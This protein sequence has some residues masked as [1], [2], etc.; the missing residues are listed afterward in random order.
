V[1]ALAEQQPA[2][3][4]VP[5][6]IVGVIAAC[7]V[8]VLAV[9]HVAGAICLAVVLLGSLNVY[10]LAP[11]HD[12]S[13][14]VLSLAL[15]ALVGVMALALRLSE[16][17]PVARDAVL[18][19]MLWLALALAVPIV[20]VDR[21]MLQLRWRQVPWQ[22][23][24]AACGIPAGVAGELILRPQPLAGLG[25]PAR[26]AAV[27]LALAVLVAPSLE[28]LFRWVLNPDLVTLYGR[29]GLLLLNG[30]FAS[31]YLGTRSAGF[32]LLMGVA[33]LGLSV[34]VSRTRVVWGAVAAHAILIIGVML[35]W[36]AVLP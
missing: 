26:A 16:I 29:A 36:P 19:A 27:A 3:R 7:N 15:V 28:L 5:G 1:T 33:G 9:G 23:L 24:I 8:V 2:R 12:R 25:D 10:V 4:L 32:V 17:S 6:A 18:G 13:P 20:P 31:L 35:V 30:L 14:V 34:A 21:T 22:L 11:Q